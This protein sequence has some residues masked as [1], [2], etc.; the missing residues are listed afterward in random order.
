MDIFSLGLL[1]F[2]LVTGRR[3]YTS[4]VLNNT[5]PSHSGSST[6]CPSLSAA[7]SSSFSEQ[8]HSA[9]AE[10]SVGVHQAARREPLTSCYAACMQPLLEGCLALEPCDRP[11]AQGVYSRLVVCPG[12]LPQ[13]NFITAEV[14]KA[15]YV[16]STGVVL[17]Q[18]ADSNKMLEI[19]PVS[20]TAQTRMLHLPCQNEAVSCF[21]CAEEEMYLCSESGLVSS[22][23]LPHLSSGLIA[24]SPLPSGPLSIFTHPDKM[25]TRILVGLAN[26]MVAVY[27][28]RGSQH[29]L[30]SEPKM[31]V[32]FDHPDL[33]RVAVH[34]AIYH[35]GMLWCGCGRHLIVVRPS[36]YEL[37]HMRPA[38]SDSTYV[39]HLVAS[40]RY[41]WAGLHESC[42]LAVFCSMMA[43]EGKSVTKVDQ[44]KCR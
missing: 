11:T 4:N 8:Q 3:L 39:T 27:T 25:G 30:K 38:S 37:L 31:V 21:V 32:L 19:A 6:K 42:E 26:G 23:S 22:L 18:A 33:A 10:H 40:G 29:P 17:G 1:L 34:C 44:I 41:V 43:M 35:E 20:W 15:I 14:K 13:A 16:P 9:G 28:P 36:D 24:S 7:L 5:G 12:S 2:H